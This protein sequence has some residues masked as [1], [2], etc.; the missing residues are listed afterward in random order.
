MHGAKTIDYLTNNQRLLFSAN[1][2]FSTP[3][4]VWEIT[5]ISRQKHQNRS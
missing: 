3:L 1:V 5:G 2:D 4:K